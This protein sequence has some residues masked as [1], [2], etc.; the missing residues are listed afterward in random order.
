MASFLTGI[1]VRKTEGN[2]IKA[3][4]SADQVIANAIGGAT[5]FPSLEF[6]LDY[7]KLEGACDPGYAC[8]Y[9]NN[10][11][12]RSETAPAIKEVN[13]RIVFDRMFA[14]RKA[15]DAAA[16]ARDQE[17]FYNRS[18]LDFA[19]EGITD[20]NH[21][22][23]AGDRQRMDEYLTSIREI[24]L[25]L[26]RPP[27]EVSP[28]I[29]RGLV[30]PV[31]IP[32]TFR[33]HFRL[34]ADLM[35]LGFQMDLTRVCTFELGVE[36]SRRTYR[37]IGISEEHHGLTHHAYDPVKIEKVGKI[38][39]YMI[40]QFAYLIEKMKSVRE[41]DRALLDNSMVLFGNGNGD[42]NRHDHDDLPV[43]LAGKGGGSINPGRHVRYA[44][45]TPFMNLVL[46]LMDRMGVKAERFGDS[47]GRLPG[48]TT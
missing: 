25:R 29:S 39:R 20:L 30:R 23:G 9:S 31:R 2:N 28:E 44:R 38:D 5:R 15:T 1:Q 18:I 14:G 16:E 36:Q 7:G 10:L 22:L 19:R 8:V 37:E 4:I 35:V 12:W 27:L 3:A 43:L 21:K 17:E 47:T 6:G 45:G 26:D 42:G 46:S 33:E 40:E 48:L 41:G 34:M 24:E 32:D 11:S 13:P